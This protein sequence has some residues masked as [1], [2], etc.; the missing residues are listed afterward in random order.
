MSLL[1]SETKT[2]HRDGRE[3][4]NG[5]TTLGH[6]ARRPLARPPRTVPGKPLG[7]VPQST[8]AL[9][10]SIATAWGIS[11][12]GTAT[13]GSITTRR[14]KAGGSANTPPSAQSVSLM[15]DFKRVGRGEKNPLTRLE[16]G[17]WETFLDENTYRERL[18]PFSKVKL[19]IV[20]DNGALDRIPAYIRRVIQDPA[21]FDFAG[22][23]LPE[24]SFRWENPGFR[25]PEDFTPLIYEAHTPAW[26]PKTGTWARG[27]N[28]PTRSCPKYPTW[29]NNTLQL[30][31]VQEHPYYGI[32]RVSC[33][34]FLRAFLALRHA[35]RPALPHRH[36]TRD[37]DRSGDGPGTF[38]RGEKPGGGTLRIRRQ[39]RTLLRGRSFGQSPRMGFQ[40][41]R[42]R[43]DV[44][45]AIPAVQ[46]RLLDGGIPLRRIPLRR[47]NLHAVLPPTATRPSTVTTSISARTPTIRPVLYLQTANTLIRSRYPHCPVHR[48]RQ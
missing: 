24:S 12:A 28:L 27:A 14:R 39:T 36:G 19:R 7:V 40:T 13:S 23:F 17:T 10:K 22:Q 15:G 9:S 45:P 20:S 48:R 46:H 41:V 31:A 1:S 34:Q 47:G 11:P 33:I 5:K 8:C 32:V 42:L 29:V 25:L 44:R 16:S 2:R 18:T 3:R 35:R 30:M 6:R 43:Q 38:P 4:K 21:T 26:L 37:G